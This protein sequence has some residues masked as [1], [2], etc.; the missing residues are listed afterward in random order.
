[1]FVIE[2]NKLEGLKDIGTIIEL[3]PND[4]EFL[5]ESKELLD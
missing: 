4:V 3:V 1:M 5:W 2:H